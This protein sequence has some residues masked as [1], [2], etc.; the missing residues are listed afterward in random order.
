MRDCLVR[1][2]GFGGWMYVGALVGNEWGGVVFYFVF[3]WEGEFGI[4]WVGS[5]VVVLQ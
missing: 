3:G 2:G 4:D 1:G 5:G